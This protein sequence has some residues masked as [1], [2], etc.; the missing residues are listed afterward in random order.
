MI[1]GDHRVTATSIARQLGILSGRNTVVDGD[2]MDEMSDAEL[3]KTLKTA[4]VFARVSP[5]DK[6]RIV[7]AL[8]LN[9]EVVAMTGDGVNDSPALKSADIGIAMGITGTDVAKDASDMILLDDNFTTIEYAVREGRRV[10]RN[11]QKVIQFL[12]A[13]N[14]A[15]VITILVAA[16]IGAPQP[17]NAVQILVINLVTDTLPALALGVDPAHKDIMKERPVRSGSLFDSGLVGRVILHGSFIASVTIT[18]FFIGIFSV[19][20]G[21]TWTQIVNLNASDFTYLAGTTMAF[22]T[23]ALS[24]LI[25]A[26][27][28]RSN[29]ISLLTGGNG[30]NKA[31]RIAMLGSLL[32]L[33]GILL[34]PVM[35]INVFGVVGFYGSYNGID[36]GQYAWLYIIM[37]LL[38]FVPT[39]F[40]EV[41][42]F[43]IRA[44][45]KAKE[46]RALEKEADT[47]ALRDTMKAMVKE[48]VKEAN[49]EARIITQLKLEAKDGEVIYDENGEP[50]E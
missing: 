7:D 49:E 44:V 34:I 21:I 38:S 1:T 22:G 4:T 45:D 50:I 36:A 9:G 32:V 16:I 24:Q 46:E 37:I 8:R 33:I 27:N 20:P 25:H 48:A 19:Q 39:L 6:L 31:L 28:Q 5:S 47:Q 15:E 30:K 18:A 41:Q 13:G 11:I 10:Y 42:K 40:V 26:A 17:I 3:R 29:K 35:N 2:D 43:V 23:L 14:I 12:L